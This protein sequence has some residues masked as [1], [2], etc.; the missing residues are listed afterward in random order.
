MKIR[1]K[2][3]VAMVVICLISI[4]SMVLINYNLSI[5]SLENEI[6]ERIQGVAANTAKELDKWMAVQKQSL[7]E[8]ASSILY[9]DNYDYNYV[10]GF[11]NRQ[12]KK[13]E[14]NEYYI[15]LNDGSLISGSGWIPPDDYITTERDWYIGAVSNENEDEIYISEPYVDAKTKDLIVS[16][17][18]PLKKDEKILGVLCSDISIK[19][20]IKVISN[21]KVGKDSYAFLVDDKGNILAHI[22]AEYKPSESGYANI[23][24]IL[25]GKLINIMKQSN[26]ALKDRKITDY[27]KVDRCF[28]FDDMKESGWKVG[29]AVSS[30]EVLKTINRV[31]KLTMITTVIILAIALVA[32]IYIANSISK[33][34]MESVEIA[35]NIGNLNLTDDVINEINIERE[36][37]I[38]SMMRSYQ[39]IIEKLRAFMED[40]RESIKVTNQVY[41]KTINKLNLLTDEAEDTSATTEQLSAGMQEVAATTISIS[42][43]TD[44]IDKATADFASKVEE[45]AKTANEIS[46][47]AE[48]LNSQFIK[49]KDRTM[50]IY[51]K[52]KDEVSSAIKASKEVNKISVLSNAILEITDQTNLL[53]LNAAIEAA[54][55]GESGRGFAVVA[56][57]IRKLAETSQETVGEIK[58]IAEGIISSVNQLVDNTMYLSNFLEKD[59]V[60]DYAMMM[61]AV[62]QYKEDGAALSNMIS[63]LSAGSEELAAS[64]GEISSAVKEVSTTI[65]DSTKAT[66]NIA[67]QNVRIAEIISEINDI[68]EKNRE[69]SQKLNEIVSQVNM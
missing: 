32:S 27:D 7:E 16:I 51:G 39:N 42:E 1:S 47:R 8:I 19:H 14:G 30:K 35:E 54:R 17:S 11:L 62:E 38:G 33:P 15:G 18:R 31:V 66:T 56:D 63:D 26:L 41:E 20:L 9:N 23:N 13:N 22:N 25:D 44:E 40:M 64:I 61:E 53:A 49:A 52:S 29:L 65:E 58:S 4:F 37:E 5:K 46:E 28:L 2:I 34:I 6:G 68:M 43:S 50:D 55:A 36:D 12:I 60:K 3:V 48:K 24:E 21:V 67:E 10:F 69:V 59:V 45:G 57:E